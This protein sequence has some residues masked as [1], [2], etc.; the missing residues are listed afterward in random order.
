MQVVQDTKPSIVSLYM[1]KHKNYTRYSKLEKVHVEFGSA[2]LRN[3]YIKLTCG[4]KRTNTQSLSLT[5]AEC[6]SS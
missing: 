3:F 6:A 4:T 5:T 2:D 1:S